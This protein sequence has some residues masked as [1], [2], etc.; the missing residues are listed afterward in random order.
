MHLN[1]QKQRRDNSHHFS[2]WPEPKPGPLEVRC[3]QSSPI[4]VEM[5][6]PKNKGSFS[7]EAA[8]LPPAQSQ[9]G[10]PTANKQTIRTSNHSGPAAICNMVHGRLGTSGKLDLTGS[11]SMP[12]CHGAC[13]QC[14]GELCAA[15]IGGEKMCCV[16]RVLGTPACSKSRK[17]PCKIAVVRGAE[18]IYEVKNR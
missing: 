6:N 18:G 16:K 1:Y 5:L 8:R 14:G 2:E 11:L 7:A 17:A 3:T 10:G 13:A 4:S 12:C 9:Y 15:Y